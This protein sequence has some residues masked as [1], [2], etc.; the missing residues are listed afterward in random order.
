[1]KNHLPLPMSQQGK[2]WGRKNVLFLSFCPHFFASPG[3]EGT[4]FDGG[5]DEAD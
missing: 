4:A 2:K 1:M 5:L 3:R